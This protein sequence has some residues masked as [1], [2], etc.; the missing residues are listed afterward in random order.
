MIVADDQALLEMAAGGDAEAQKR[1]VE[2]NMGLVWSVVKRFSGRGYELED[3][4]QVGAIGLI[5]AVRHFDTQ[6]NVRFSTYAV[7][8]IIGEIKRFL[9]DDG[10]IK[11]SR[12]LKEAASKG[13]RAEEQLRRELGREPT[14][15]EISQRCG[16]EADMLSEAFDASAS[17]ESIY[18]T[19]YDDGGKTLTVLDKLSTGSQE[20]TIINRVMVETIL[21][22]LKPRERQVLVMR[23]FQGKTQSEI[24]R[25]IGVSQ[26]QVSRI[27]KNTIQRIREKWSE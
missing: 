9:R 27:E 10:P 18:D 6:Y 1:L 2:E 17:P 16:I 13:R 15:G 19:V 24:A 21:R 7:P 26:V 14:I 23:Y 3:L 12:T 5:K 8:M 11:V 22:S 4:A 20:E 25:L